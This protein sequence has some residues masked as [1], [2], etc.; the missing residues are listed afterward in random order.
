MGYYNTNY[1][2]TSQIYDI[3]IANIILVKLI[4]GVIS[5]V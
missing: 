3:Q 2:M 4:T 5:F 1:T